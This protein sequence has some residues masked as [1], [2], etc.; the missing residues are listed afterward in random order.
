MGHK[1]EYSIRAQNV[2]FAPE[3]G[4]RGSIWMPKPRADQEC[5]PRRLHQDNR[6]ARRDRTYQEDRGI[7]WCRT[8]RSTST[9]RLIQE[10][11]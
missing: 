8:R 3:T 6:G 7:G 11:R 10:T 2:C 1:Q 5:L 4:H 9:R